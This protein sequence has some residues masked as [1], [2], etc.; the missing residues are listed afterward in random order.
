MIFVECKPDAALARH[1]TGLRGKNVISEANSK[2][3]VCN[4]L[5]RGNN[6]VGLVDEDPGA[7]PPNYMRPLRLVSS[8][9]DLGLQMYDDTRRNNRIIVL[10]PRFEEWVL[11]AASDASLRMG[12]YGLP[13][14]ASSLHRVVNAD[15][16]KLQRLL[17]DLSAADSPRLNELRRLLTDV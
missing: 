15:E 5:E 14:R 11:R 3:G 6:H 7:E 12:D 4:K 17:D 2:G 8:R 13:N 16:R 9:V 1:V 10:R